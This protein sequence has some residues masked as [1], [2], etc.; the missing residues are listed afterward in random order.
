MEFIL[1]LLKE[2][3]KNKITNIDER[4]NQIAKLKPLWT[5]SNEVALFESVENDEYIN[6]YCRFV[7]NKII[8]KFLNILTKDEISTLSSKSYEYLKDNIKIDL[9]SR[10]NNNF[11]SFTDIDKE[12]E[13]LFKYFY[14]TLSDKKEDS[15]QSIHYSMPKGMVMIEFYVLN[16]DGTVDAGRLKKIITN[17]SNLD[18]ELTHALDINKYDSMSKVLKNLNPVKYNK[19]KEY[20]S[21]N[22]FEYHAFT[23]QVISKLN[24]EWKVD[25]N[26]IL[27]LI[28]TRDYKSFENALLNLMGKD[29]EFFGYL[30]KRNKKNFIAR[31]M[32]YFYK[33]AYEEGLIP[34]PKYEE[35]TEYERDNKGKILFDE[36]DFNLYTNLLIECLKEDV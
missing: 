27:N 13:N 31:I 14:I 20:Y 5:W 8:D 15:L 21:N 28:L 26:K 24:D 34:L 19:H 10:I 29:F 30:N 17:K 7:A 25:P 9:R 6:S 4:I 12:K 1:P 22:S 36:E 23:N 16:E 33:K 11:L 3:V 18:H 35:K 2:L 32:N